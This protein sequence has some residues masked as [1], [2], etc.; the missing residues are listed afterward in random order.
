MDIDGWVDANL[1]LPFDY[2]LVFAKVIGYTKSVV[3]WHGGGKWDGL[4]FI[5]GSIV[6]YWKRKQE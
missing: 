2:D 4:H 3:A 6:K 1:Y 5:P